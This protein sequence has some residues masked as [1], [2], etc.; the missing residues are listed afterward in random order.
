M[1]TLR[2]IYLVAY[3]DDKGNIRYRCSGIKQPDGT[4][5]YSTKDAAKARRF[6]T[7]ERAMKDLNKLEKGNP[8]ILKCDLIPDVTSFTE[9]SV[10][11]H[12]EE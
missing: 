1:T 7:L 6:A 11:K 2:E 4:T 12:L 3:D 5:V 10:K 9:I 8:R